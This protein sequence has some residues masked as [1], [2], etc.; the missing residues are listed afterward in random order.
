MATCR[1]FSAHLL[2]VPALAVLITG[3][4]ARVL[5]QGE[6]SVGKSL[7]DTVRPE[8]TIVV[9]R[10][11]MGADQ[12]EVTMEDPN[13]SPDDL[14]ARVTRLGR[15][16]GSEVRGLTVGHY[17]LAP[18]NPRLTF[19][20]ALFVVDGITQPNGEF[21]RIQPI[22]RAFVGGVKGLTLQFENVQYQKWTVRTLDTAALSAEA[23]IHTAPI[24]GIEYRVLLKTNDAS[25]VE[26]PDR[27]PEPKA[28]TTPSETPREDRDYLGWIALGVAGVAAG[29]LVYLALVRRGRP[30]TP[31]RS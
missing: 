18:D 15:E 3:T 8:A 21:I 9:K 27:M 14:K 17:S 10:H 12:V 22:L 6:S 11:K 7:F 2:L 25:K 24:P 28:S 23:R 26:F 20:K 4:S 13:F 30:G 19:L 31:N 16:L 29:A 1:P 5:A